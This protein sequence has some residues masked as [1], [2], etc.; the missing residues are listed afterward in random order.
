MVD[1]SVGDEY[2]FDGER[3]FG[4]ER[5]DAGDVVARVNDD[6][7]VGV[8]VAEDGAIALECADG[9]Y[10]VNHGSL[11]VIASRTAQHG[12]TQ[13]TRIGD[14]R[15]RRECV[16]LSRNA[17]ACRPRTFETSKVYFFAGVV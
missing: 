14:K 16:D 1:V 12:F 11:R 10:L 2:L 17:Q 5:E 4:Q 13:M 3:V 6:G 9:K 7:F 15:S 8:L